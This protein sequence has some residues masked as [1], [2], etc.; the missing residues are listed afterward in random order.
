MAVSMLLIV[1]LAFIGIAI[2]VVI[3]AIVAYTERSRRN[4]TSGTESETDPTLQ[5]RSTRERANSPPS[6]ESE[7]GSALDLM[8]LEPA[9][10][11]V[12]QMILRKVEVAYPDLCAAVEALPERELLSTAELDNVLGKLIDENWITVTE[13]DGTAIYKAVLRRKSTNVLDTYAPK[14]RTGT[15]LPQNVWDSLDTKTDLG[16]SSFQSDEK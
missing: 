16:K 11:R 10:Y 12:M 8:D 9:A 1:T 13:N 3:V 5:S 4:R 7:R 6:L 2:G 15:I 14:R